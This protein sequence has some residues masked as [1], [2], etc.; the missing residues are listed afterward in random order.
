MG[1][2]WRGSFVLAL[3]RT[4][5]LCFAHSARNSV[6]LSTV[7]PM[8]R[9]TNRAAKLAGALASQVAR[10]AERRKKRASVERMPAAAT[11]GIRGDDGCGL[12]M[13]HHGSGV[14]RARRTM[15]L[16]VARPPIVLSSR[17]IHHHQSAS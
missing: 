14:G 10:L 6:A 15:I 3:R 4:R 1:P 16:L 13:W 2:Y 7:K 17:L 9:S 5:S 12:S 8:P 11:S